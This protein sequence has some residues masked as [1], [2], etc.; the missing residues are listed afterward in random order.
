MAM[1]ATSAQLYCASQRLSE[2]CSA[3]WARHPALQLFQHFTAGFIN[4]WSE[5]LA[6]SLDA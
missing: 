6:P 1:V 3:N 2:H 5:Q 4:V